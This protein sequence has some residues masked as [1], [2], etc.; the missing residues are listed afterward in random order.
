MNGSIK[1]RGKEGHSVALTGTSR[2]TIRLLIASGMFATIA[3]VAF[4]AGGVTK[5]SA[6]NGNCPRSGFD[7]AWDVYPG[8][9]IHAVDTGYGI[10]RFSILEPMTT[11][12]IEEMPCALKSWL[13][14]ASV[15]YQ[16]IRERRSGSTN[17][18][19]HP[20]LPIKPRLIAA[21]GST[22]LGSGERADVVSM[23]GKICL[24]QRL[25]VGNCRK[26]GRI[27][28]TGMA[29]TTYDGGSSESARTVG[30]VPDN[31]VSM[32]IEYP[33]FGEVPIKDNVFETTGNPGRRFFIIGRDPTG[34]VTTSVYVRS[35]GTHTP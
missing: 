18:N 1:T 27:E 12:R 35:S 25:H 4:L 30:L 28:A 32:T 26:I 19:A 6:G 33:G 14:G 7:K 34:A 10:G 22:T 29:T 17:G 3:M 15:D 20:R 31:V 24:I 5:A 8:K 16:K 13:A 11:D 9:G 23:N 21:W 2:S